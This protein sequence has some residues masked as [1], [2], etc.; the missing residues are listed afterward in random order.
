M[1]ADVVLSSFDYP[2]LHGGVL[3]LCAGKLTDSLLGGVDLPAPD[4]HECDRYTAR[5]Q[6]GA[7]AGLFDSLLE[8]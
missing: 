4:E 6:V 7:F 3:R 5:R 2:P 8:K 1:L